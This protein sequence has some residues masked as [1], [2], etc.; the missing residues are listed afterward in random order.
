MITKSGK[1]AMPSNGWKLQVESGPLIDFKGI[2]VDVSQEHEEEVL[3][4]AS[5]R[6][7]ELI[8]SGFEDTDLVISGDQL[9][10]Y[11][12]ETASGTVERVDKV[13]R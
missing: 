8:L 13:T 5:N 2:V 6:I 10:R 9:E 1:L 4:I 11:K 7:A 12:I 3:E